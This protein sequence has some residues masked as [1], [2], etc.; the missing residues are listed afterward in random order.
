[1]S[2]IFHILKRKEWESAKNAGVYQPESLR[3]DGFVHCSKTDQL[4]KVAN[5]F[6]KNERDLII[7]RIVENKVTSEIKHEPPLEAPLSDV[8]FPHIHGPLNVDAVDK[9]IEFP[10]KDDG[11]FD[12]PD[13]LLG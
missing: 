12:L 7:L 10:C 8:L 2:N 1:M 6:Y 11:T 9:E 3:R 4:L 13:D 5:S